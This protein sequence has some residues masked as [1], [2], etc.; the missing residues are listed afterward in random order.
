MVIQCLCV[1]LV[2]ILEK[3][4]ELRNADDAPRRNS[5]LHPADIGGK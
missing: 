4:D 1:A 3:Y 5:P 2:L